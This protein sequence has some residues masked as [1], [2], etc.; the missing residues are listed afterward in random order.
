V[1]RELPDHESGNGIDCGDRHGSKLRRGI[2][3]GEPFG[4]PV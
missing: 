2:G 4:P 1:C 3:G